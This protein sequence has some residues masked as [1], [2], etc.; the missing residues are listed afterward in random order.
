MLDFVVEND[1]TIKYLE[2]TPVSAPGHIP[3]KNL[4]PL[5]LQNGFSQTKDEKE[6][7]VFQKNN[8][9]VM[10]RKCT[11]ELVEELKE[12]QSYCKK[13]SDINIAPDG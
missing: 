13:N 8:A 9:K 2:L 12:N 5:L 11:C 6:Q 4:I 1:L 7:M 3:T 10:L